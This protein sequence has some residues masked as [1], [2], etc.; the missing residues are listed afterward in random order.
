MNRKAAT[1]GGVC[2]LIGIPVLWI[3]G[4]PM[5]AG[6]SALVSLV[7]WASVYLPSGQRGG[8][9]AAQSPCARA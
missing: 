6:I 3:A 5:F 9:P 8:P 2:G 7:C 1:A 4:S